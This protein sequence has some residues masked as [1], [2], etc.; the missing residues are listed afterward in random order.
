MLK[1]Q[2]GLV[3]TSEV[4]FQSGVFSLD[5][6]KRAAYR[7]LGR[8]TVTIEPQEAEVRC[9]L[10]FPSSLPEASANE[11]VRDFKDEV[12]DQDLRERIAAETSPLRNAILAHAFSRTGLKE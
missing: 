5:A 1:V 8:A 2:E 10:E 6:I 12:L 4:R 9:T 3:A 11:I 7:L